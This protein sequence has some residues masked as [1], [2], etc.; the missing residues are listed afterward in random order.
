M[1]GR[2]IWAEAGLWDSQD[3]IQALREISETRPGVVDSILMEEVDRFMES[4]LKHLLDYVA[5]VDP[6]LT[7]R[8]VVGHKQIQKQLVEFSKKHPYSFPGSVFAR[9]GV[10]P[11][12]FRHYVRFQPG[13]LDVLLALPQILSHRISLSYVAATE[14]DQAKLEALGG[15]L[16]APPLSVFLKPQLRV[17]GKLQAEG[18]GAPIGS[19]YPFVL[20]FHLGDPEEQAWF[21]GRALHFVSVG[22]FYTVALDSGKVAL[23][24]IQEALSQLRQAQQTEPEVLREEVVCQFLHLLGMIYHGWMD[25]VVEYYEGNP[26]GGDLPPSQRSTS[27]AGLSR[28]AQCAFWS[29]D[30]S[31][32]P[33]YR[34]SEQPVLPLFAQRRPRLC[35]LRH[36]VWLGVSRLGVG[37]LDI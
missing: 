9:Y 34:C 12:K 28:G 4:R 24:K 31:G 14:E 27:F 23:E 15:V 10:I 29:S 33:G 16:Q 32:S 3:I 18:D 22:G 5:S 19:W 25:R 37:T 13:G 11:A 30:G 20:D 1:P 6:N 8:Q 21:L 26:G 36:S 17:G 7:M 35:R 2:D